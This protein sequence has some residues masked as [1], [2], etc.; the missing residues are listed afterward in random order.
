MPSITVQIAADT[1][2]CCSRDD[3][4]GRAVTAESKPYL[5]YISDHSYRSAYRFPLDIPQ[6]ATIDVAYLRVCAAWTY[7]GTT[8]GFRVGCEAVDNCGP[9]AFETHDT[10]TMFSNM[11]TQPWWNV[12]VD[13]TAGSWYNSNTVKVPLQE[14]IDRSG[15]VSGNYAGFLVYGRATPVGHRQFYHYADGAANAMKLHVEWHVRS[16]IMRPGLGV[17]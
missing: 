12:S 17:W 1:D 5:G 9:F 8:C 6:G 4:V 3:N 10:Q 15:W 7:T 13:W 14:I 16:P 2:D 11:T